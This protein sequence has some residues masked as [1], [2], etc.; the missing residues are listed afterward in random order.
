MP[1]TTSLRRY[2]KLLDDVILSGDESA[3]KELQD[4]VLAVF[5]PEF[6]GMRT[7]LTNY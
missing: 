1:S 7:K 3:A 4:E 5:E 6:D 2:I